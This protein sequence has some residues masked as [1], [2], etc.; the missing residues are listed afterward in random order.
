MSDVSEFFLLA[1]F[2]AFLV[3][4]LENAFSLH[5]WRSASLSINFVWCSFSWSCFAWNNVSVTGQMPSVQSQGPSVWLC[6]AAFIITLENSGKYRSSLLLYLVLSQE[7]RFQDNGLSSKLQTPL[8][9]SNQSIYREDQFE[10][11]DQMVRW[12]AYHVLPITE[13]NGHLHYAFYQGRRTMVQLYLTDLQ[14]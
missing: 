7:A 14:G 9:D 3:S 13:S 1:C 2:H 8:L 4:S 6:W 11:T 10:P 5:P 12:S